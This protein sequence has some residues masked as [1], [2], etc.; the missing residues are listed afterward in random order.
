MSNHSNLNEITISDIL[1]LALPVKTTV[2]AGATQARR[3]IRWVSLLTTWNDLSIQI[4]PGDLVLIPSFLQKQISDQ[5]LKK[6]L[7]EMRELDCVGLVVFE[8]T[9]DFICETAT[10]LSLTL[11][12]VP[13]STLTREAHRDIA[14]LLVDR[15]FATAERGMQL[16]RKLAEMS[17]EEQ[18][19]TAM[20][21]LISKLTGKIVIVQD[22]R[23]EIRATSV[24]RNNQIDTTTL[25]EMI[26]QREQLPSVLRNRKAAA[27]ARPTYWQQ[28]LPI[29]NMGRLVSPIVSGDR[30]R[31][32]LSLIGPADALDLL[33]SLAVEHG[34]AAC[35]L[36]MAKAKAVSEA[37]K[38]LRGNF[39]EGLL[40]GTLPRKEIER[41]EG[42]LDHNTKQP[43][44]IIT[45]TW[46]GI[47]TPSLRR[48]ET[49]VSW[50]LQNHR[51]SAL[52]HIYG[53]QHLCIFQALKNEADL[54]S[55]HDFARR[56]Q[57][58]VKKE[59]PNATMIAGMSG[60]APTLAEWP[61]IYAEALQAM[62]LSERLQLHEVVEFNSLGVYRL[63]GQLEDIPAVRQFTQQVIGP[64]ADY[65]HQH[66]SSLVKTIDS[67][68]GHHGNISQT[69]E[70]LFIHR[71]TLLY[72]LERIQ[73]LTQH[74]LNQSNMRLALH[75]ALK[76]WQ[77][78]PD[79]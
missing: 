40:A 27:R 78:R 33:D 29:E 71:N 42:R 75:L 9:S 21:D 15:Q 17:R 49:A 23:L 24:P 53:D 2:L 51:R 19:L 10:D 69:A 3:T 59:F 14:T 62:Q 65:D 64:L 34:A 68:F 67:Y 48:L 74:D 1:R 47:Q 11:L 58:H 26:K 52:V 41:L 50:L 54:E 25:Y 45:A 46:E 76:L 70:A 28:M 73:D 4:Q 16:Y 31:G 22:K 7:K 30:A 13:T 6:K 57:D 38:A 36:E 35:A 55:V 20:T 32:Y 79:K 63:L 5:N 66:R 43:H 12:Q 56:M 37:K 44:A 77:L 39:L 8:N 18:G 72:R 61:T 60:P